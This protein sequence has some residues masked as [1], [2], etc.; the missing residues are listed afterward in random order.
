MHAGL[1]RRGN[2]EARVAILKN[3]FMRNPAR[4]RSYEARE[5]HTGW[6]VL[7][8]N[9]WVIARLITA[10]AEQQRPT[11]RSHAALAATA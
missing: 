1:K 4:G 3:V 6:A 2:I 8:H 11:S 10:Q 9:L 5:Y 7:T